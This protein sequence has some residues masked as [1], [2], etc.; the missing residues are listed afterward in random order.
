[1]IKKAQYLL[2]SHTHF[3]IFIKK[4]FSVIQYAFFDYV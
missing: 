4:N 2:I 3:D 1:M